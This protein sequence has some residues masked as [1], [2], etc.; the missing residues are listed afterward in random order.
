MDRGAGPPD[1]PD[2]DAPG[3][4]AQFEPTEQAQ[5]RAEWEAT[6][7]ARCPRCAVAMHRRAIGGG[8]FGLGYAR[9]RVWLL[10]PRCHRS[11]IFDAARGTRN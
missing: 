5:V 3:E 4:R 10:C 1:P 9:R 2:T 7:T 6:T 8:S 11:V